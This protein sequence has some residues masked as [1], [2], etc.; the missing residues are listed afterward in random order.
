M[1]VAEQRL[2]ERTLFPPVG[3]QRQRLELTQPN[4][5]AAPLRQRPEQQRFLNIGGQQEQVHD[6]GNPGTGYMTQVRELRVARDHAHMQQ[7]FAADRQGQQPRHTRH[8]TGRPGKAR[9][10]LVWWK[11]GAARP[12]PAAGTERAGDRH[13]HSRHGAFS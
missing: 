2:P 13:Q 4:R 6:L 7:V 1:Q 5:I 12:S 10:F 9:R 3:D 8:P 11:G